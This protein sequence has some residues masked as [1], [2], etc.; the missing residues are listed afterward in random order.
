MTELRVL[1]LSASLREKSYNTALLR[2][3]QRLAP[4]GMSVVD[5]IATTSLQRGE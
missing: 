3:A 1:A 2:E 5:P 4:H